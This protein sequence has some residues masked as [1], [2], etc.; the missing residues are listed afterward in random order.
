MTLI[1]ELRKASNPIAEISGG[2]DSGGIDYINEDIVENEDELREKIDDLLS[3]H[4]GS[5]A[6][7]FSVTGQV[8]FENDKLYMNFDEFDYDS[9]E[10]VQT[11]KITIDL[12][13]KLKAI[14]VEVQGDEITTQVLIP[15]GVLPRNNNL[16]DIENKILPLLHEGYE[17]TINST[18]T[19]T[20][21]GTELELLVIEEE[22]KHNE[23][24]IELTI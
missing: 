7:N 5:F 17:Y 14:E 12:N 21:S 22:Y 19:P 4:Y 24:C 11:T 13:F 15:F 9:R 16:D 6:G 23:I 10:T 20:D 1:E 3:E 18:L 2:N 8:V